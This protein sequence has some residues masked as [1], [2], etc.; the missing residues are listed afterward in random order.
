MLAEVLRGLHSFESVSEDHSMLAFSAEAS[1]IGFMARSPL[2]IGVSAAWFDCRRA[3][4]RVWKGERAL[5]LL[6]GL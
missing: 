3:D 1:S 6:A 5:F 2:S 4:E